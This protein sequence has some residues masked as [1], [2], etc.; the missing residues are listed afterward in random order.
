VE[1]I[2]A[3]ICCWVDSI[4]PRKGKTVIIPNSTLGGAHKG[5]PIPPHTAFVH[6]KNHQ[7]DGGGW[8]SSFQNEDNLVFMLHGDV[9]TFDPMPGGGTIDIGD[10]PHV[11]AGVT[12]DPIC[13]AADEIRPGFLEEPSADNVLGLVHLPADAP[14]STSAN[15]HGAVYATMHMPETEVTITATPFDGGPPRVLR[16]TDP[17]AHV[18]IANVTLA[19][20]LLGIPAPEDDH[21]YLVCGMFMPSVKPD[22][23]SRRRGASSKGRRATVELSEIALPKHEQY[24][25]LKVAPRKPMRDFLATFAAG[26]SDSQWP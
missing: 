8:A 3:G 19:D 24:A 21:Q 4:P 16:I 15:G 18:F 6:A 17:A 20:Y 10:L 12:R 13:P 23:F 14:V 7:V 25:A 5:S 2:F 9:L 11:R 22:A 26:C 1:I